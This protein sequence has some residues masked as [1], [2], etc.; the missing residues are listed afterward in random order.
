MRV[1]VNGAPLY[2]VTLEPIHRNDLKK[3]GTFS[4]T[5]KYRGTIFGIIPI[6]EKY[7]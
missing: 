3:Y 5:V 6:G 4:T 7:L 2:T 1:E